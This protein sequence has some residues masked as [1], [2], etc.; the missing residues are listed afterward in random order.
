MTRKRPFLA[1]LLALLY[2]GLGH[3]YLRAWKRA[4]GW[5]LL[6]VGTVAVVIPTEVLDRIEPLDSPFTISETIATT[7]STGELTAL[8]VVVGF[9]V[10]DAYLLARRQQKTPSQSAETTGASRCPNC[11]KEPDEELDF[12]PWCAAD[13]NETTSQ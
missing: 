10:A 12:C 13:L 11:G 8:L 6:A 9:S 4:I 7:A 2:P 5:F 1:G 3:I